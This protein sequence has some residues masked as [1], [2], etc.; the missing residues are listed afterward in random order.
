MTRVPFHPASPW[1]L[2]H[3]LALTALAC[4]LLLAGLSVWFLGAVA[5]AG[6]TAAAMTFNFHVPG[7]LVRLFAIGRTVAKYGER[8]VGHDAALRDQMRRRSDLF[9]R[10]ASS[11]IVRRAGWQL[12]DPDRL[13]DYLDDVEDLDNGRLRVDLPAMSL[14]AGSLACLITTLIVVP[15]A[16]LPIAVLLVVLAVVGH[17]VI[18]AGTRQMESIR[19]E[20]REAG[21]KMGAAL[22]AVIPLQAEGKWRDEVAAALAHSAGAESLGCNL[23]T[24]AARLD[25][26]V[27]SFGPVYA[28]SVMAAA[29]IGGA[30]GEGLLLPAFLAFSWFALAEAGQG[31]SRLLLAQRRRRIAARE[32]DHLVEDASDPVP[33]RPVRELP[34]G[35][36]FENFQHRAPDGR[37]IGEP[38]DASFVR[39]RPTALVG[40]SGCGK[41][42][43]LKQIAGWLGDDGGA[44]VSL[45]PA[46]RRAACAFCPHDAVVLAD[47]VRAN[48]FAPAASEAEMKMAL[49]AVELEDR[50]GSVGGLDAWITQDV[51]S[52]G[53]AQRLN[54]ARAWLS[55]RPVILLDEPTEHLDAAQGARI[56]ARLLA[57]LSERIV[58]FST[59]RATGPGIKKLQL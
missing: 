40:P 14:C 11:Q 57:R 29:W 58:I 42:S 34:L 1:R 27:A 45:P 48:L 36:R 6:L 12:G 50:L 38:L 25:A 33:D 9:V 15:L 30:R 17:E 35:L 22:A 10:M 18:I 41:T 53:E 49:A 4:G 7:A 46:G 31:I 56:L 5:L 39:G 59:H 26:L 2:A 28:V 44:E 51:L 13:A 54:L 37:L 43:L 55:D 21:R 19:S 52:L 47:T 8:V 20:R 3:L 23:R 24:S 32:I 16:A